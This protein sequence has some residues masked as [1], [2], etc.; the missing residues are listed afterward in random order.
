MNTAAEFFA[1]VEAR[2]GK[3]DKANRNPEMLHTYSFK[4]TDGSGNV[5]KTW[6]LDLINVALE[7][8]DKEA[9][10]TM[11]FSEADLLDVGNGKATIEEK[12][13]AGKVTVEG[14]KDY[15]KLLKPFLS[16]L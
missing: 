12:V 9:E 6:F 4:I 13:A 8:A 14:N 2:L 10:C 16:T 11:T 7:V 1:K 15:A 5:V 3:V